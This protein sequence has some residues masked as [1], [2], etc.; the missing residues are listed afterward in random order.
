MRV[1]IDDNGQSEKGNRLET[2]LEYPD[3]SLVDESLAKDVERLIL[4]LKFNPIEGIS[5]FRLLEEEI[6]PDGS[7][8]I[9]Q[10]FIL[11]PDVSYSLFR[12]W[13]ELDN[14]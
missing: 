1:L 2:Y 6:L 4:E 14:A 12:H 10:E 3:E 13:Q 5:G 8:H 7:R 9:S 11:S